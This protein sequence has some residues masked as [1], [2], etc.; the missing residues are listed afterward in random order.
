M[1]YVLDVARDRLKWGYGRIIN[2]VYLYVV[3]RSL[4]DR[5][6]ADDETAD[7]SR[8]LEV[9]TGARARQQRYLTLDVK[10]T[11]QYVKEITEIIHNCLY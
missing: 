5:V 8:E 11:T 7:I 3:V 6:N 9:L 2:H 10:N 4:I 1:R